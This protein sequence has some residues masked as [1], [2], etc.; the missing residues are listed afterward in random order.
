MPMDLDI[1]K[2][3]AGL[4]IFLFGMHL[5]EDSVDNATD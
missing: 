3:S 1:W 2:L 5:I 4:G